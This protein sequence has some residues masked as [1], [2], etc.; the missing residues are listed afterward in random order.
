MALSAE[1]RKRR[2]AKAE[3]DRRSRER[4]KVKQFKFEVGQ[5]EYNLA[6]RYAGLRDD[7]AHDDAIAAPAIGKLLR[8]GL[9]A[10]VVQEEQKR[11]KK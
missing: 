3:A 2:H 9:V 4:R 6:V 8:M 11:R 5:R 10:L 1:E 7:Q